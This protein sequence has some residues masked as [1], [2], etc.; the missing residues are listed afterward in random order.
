MK[1]LEQ[2]K[3]EFEEIVKKYNLFEPKLAEKISI[4][5]TKNKTTSKDFAKEFNLEEN[6]AK[7]FLEFIQKGIEFKEKHIDKN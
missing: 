7:I 3:K 1:K 5:L 2:H 6:D 4:Y